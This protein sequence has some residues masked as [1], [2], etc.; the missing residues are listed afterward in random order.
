[1]CLHLI[2]L[3]EASF[4]TPKLN[5]RA[6]LLVNKWVVYKEQRPV[7]TKLASVGIFVS[8]SCMT[9]IVST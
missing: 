4:V 5:Y 2:L 8:R 6:R 1:M 7:G 9:E 3:V